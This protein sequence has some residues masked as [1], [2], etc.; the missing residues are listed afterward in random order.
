MSQFPF[1]DS[2]ELYY[3]LGPKIPCYSITNLQCKRNSNQFVGF[4]L[5]NPLLKGIVKW[6]LL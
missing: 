2:L 4:V 6:T 3:F 1:R 5:P